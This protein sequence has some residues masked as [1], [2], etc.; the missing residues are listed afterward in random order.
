MSYETYYSYSY[1]EYRSAVF[2]LV[3]FVY[4]TS[5]KYVLCNNAS[6]QDD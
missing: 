1:T 4:P 6:D 2:L 3:C 5:L